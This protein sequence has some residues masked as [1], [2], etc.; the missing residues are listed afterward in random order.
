MPTGTHGST[1]VIPPKLRAPNTHWGL[2]RFTAIGMV[3]GVLWVKV[4][5]L[6]FLILG[7]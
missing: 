1:E 3:A 7:L 2:F 5:V 6:M 4:I